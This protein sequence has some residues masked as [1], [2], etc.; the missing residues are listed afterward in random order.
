MT[1]QEKL[2]IYSWT[3]VGFGVKR[4]FSILLRFVVNNRVH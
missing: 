4:K 1:K 3:E 2:E